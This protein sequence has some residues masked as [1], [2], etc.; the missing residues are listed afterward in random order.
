MLTVVSEGER[1]GSK[2]LPIKTICK[3]HEENISLLHVY[4]TVNCKKGG[5]YINKHRKHK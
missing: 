4:K 5:N 2:R 1:K 3:L